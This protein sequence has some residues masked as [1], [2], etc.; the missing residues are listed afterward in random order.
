MAFTREGWHCQL[1]LHGS[2]VVLEAVQGEPRL[3]CSL[4]PGDSPRD[5]AW[6]LISHPRC[7]LPAA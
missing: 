7:L 6:E 2:Q 4:Q 3:S 5:C 1:V